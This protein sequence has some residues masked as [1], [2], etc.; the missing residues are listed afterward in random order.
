MPLSSF[1]GV[2]ESCDR[3]TSGAAPSDIFSGASA[4]AVDWQ[5]GTQQSIF[6]LIGLGMFLPIAQSAIFPDESAAAFAA[7]GANASP[8][9]QRIRIS[10]R[11][12]SI[13]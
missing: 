3:S 1:T 7:T 12:T 2:Q 11:F 8:S 9:A 5:A 13:G 6:P 10:S 4:G